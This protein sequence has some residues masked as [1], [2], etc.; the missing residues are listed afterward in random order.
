LI[1]TIGDEINWKKRNNYLQ[2]AGYFPTYES[3]EMPPIVV[4]VDTSGSISNE[5][6]SQYLGEIREILISCNIPDLWLIQCDAAIHSVEHLSTDSV[7]AIS[8]TKIMGRGGTIFTPVF[9]YVETNNRKPPVLIYL[10]DCYGALEGDAPN[11]DVVWCV[12][13]GGDVS[14]Y[15]R[16]GDIIN[17]EK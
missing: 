13:G 3:E 6:L 11:Y 17:I 12:S 9:D 16:W 2:R 7:G 1:K 15:L 4:A 5:D 10:T 14:S 8:N